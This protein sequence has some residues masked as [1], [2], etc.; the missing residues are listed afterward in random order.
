MMRNKSVPK[1]CTSMATLIMTSPFKTCKT[2]IA[3]SSHL[4]NSSTLSKRISSPVSNASHLWWSYSVNNA[5][6]KRQNAYKSV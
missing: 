6:Y 1:I 2:M 5:D 4:G 3:G